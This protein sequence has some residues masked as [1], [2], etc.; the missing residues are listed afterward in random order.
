MDRNLRTS[1]CPSS[2]QLNFP[3]RTHSKNLVLRLSMQRDSQGYRKCKKE[4][5]QTSRLF[6]PHKHFVKTQTMNGNSFMCMKEFIQ[7][8]AIIFFLALLIN[9]LSSES[10]KKDHLL[11]VQSKVC[12]ENSLLQQLH[13]VAV[14][15]RAEACKDIVTLRE[16]KYNSISTY[17]KK[18]MMS[19]P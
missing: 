17:T 18:A 10:I 9:Y 15:L 8:S 5:E 11:K 3:D 6:S 1:L 2:V 7:Q 4:K 13:H 19:R 12:G 16:K 14:L